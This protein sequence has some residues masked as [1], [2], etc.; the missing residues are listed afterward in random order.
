M[1]YLPEICLGNLVVVAPD[2]LCF[3]ETGFLI[4]GA[5]FLLTFG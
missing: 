2:I 3:G 1:F 5:V 4:F